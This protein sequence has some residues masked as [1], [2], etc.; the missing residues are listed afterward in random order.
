MT[1]EQF[2]R[3]NK[4]DDLSRGKSTNIALR[5][6][7][8]IVA[9]KLLPG[10]GLDSENE[11][12]SYFAV[13]RPNV[14]QALL[15]LGV[16]GLVNT[17]HGV[18]T[19]VSPS[20]RWNL[21]DSLVLE[22]FSAS[23]NLSVMSSEL[24]EL[25]K[26]VEVECAR[27]AAQRITEGELRQLKALLEQMGR[28]QDDVEAITRVDFAFHEVIIAASHNRFFR[29]IMS[30][31]HALLLDARYMTMASGGAEGRKRAFNHHSSIYEAISRHDS[32]AAQAAMLSHMEQLE[33][34]MTD[35]LSRATFK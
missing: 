20:E 19:F 8:R 16:A 6:A 26:I 30:Y 3:A 33:Q 9:G 34:D 22:A 23:G 15:R 25:R 2:K 12:A 31:L 14:R 28:V 35:A 29:G 13:S 32:H 27:L 4:D 10:E 17:R 7:A 11:L 1:E 21:F 18:G 24:V 5:I